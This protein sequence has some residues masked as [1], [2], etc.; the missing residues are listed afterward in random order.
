MRRFASGGFG[1]LVCAAALAGSFAA[2]SASQD[3]GPGLLPTDGGGGGDSGG[4][5]P[6]DDTG[7]LLDGN[8]P[9]TPGSTTEPTDC[10]GAAA[11]K[12]Y[13]GCDYW[14]TVT[15]N[16]VWSVFDYAVI[17]ANAGTNAANITITGPNGVNQTGSVAPGSLEKFYLPWVPSLK[18]PDTDACGA[19]APM[20]GSVLAKASAYHLV[21][22]S[23]VTVYQFNALEYKAAGGPAGQE[24]VDLPGLR[25]VVR[26]LR[27]PGRL[28]LVLERRLAA[29]PEHRDDGE[30]PR[31]RAAWLERD[32]PVRQH[33]QRDRGLHGHHGDGRR[34]RGDGEGLERRQGHRGRRRHGDQ[35]RRNAQAEHE[36]GRR[37]RARRRQHHAV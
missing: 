31:R 27:R 12:S 2:C 15:A 17:V 4:F 33:H 37:R 10:P 24:L 18:G 16:N 14:P 7:F 30:L 32:R 9:E 19:A 23:P 20:P 6:G 13:V 35:R 22:S 8:S 26:E 21:S 25:A 28:L 29:A 36:R 1:V 3:K 11:A 34:H 5:N